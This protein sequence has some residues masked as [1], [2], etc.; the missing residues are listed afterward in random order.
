MPLERAETV[1]D[2]DE[3]GKAL[4][5]TNAIEDEYFR[6]RALAVLSLLRLCGKRRTEI[7]WIP[8]DNFRIENGLLTV[9]FTLEKKK[10]NHKKCPGC[11]TKIPGLPFFARN[12]G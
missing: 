12:S 11:N 6:L 10:R 3:L 4:D 5:E 8:L 2:D 9:T 7:S 1:I